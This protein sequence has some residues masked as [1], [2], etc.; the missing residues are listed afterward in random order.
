[1][2]A[3]RGSPGGA[4]TRNFS[5]VLAGRYALFLLGFCALIG[6]MASVENAGLPH[7]WIGA[8][9]LVD[10]VGGRIVETE[11]YHPTDPASH[12]F[13]GETPRNRTMFAGPARVPA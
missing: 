1:M 9:F 5:R 12:S 3:E 6:V 10:G 7:S 8:T 2:A 4:G 13:R 11:A